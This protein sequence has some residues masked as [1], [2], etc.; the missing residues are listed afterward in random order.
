MTFMFAHF[1][2]IYL[3]LNDFL[4]SIYHR[5]AYYLTM[6]IEIDACPLDD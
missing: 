5:L 6:Y 3:V 4:N 1:R 2:F